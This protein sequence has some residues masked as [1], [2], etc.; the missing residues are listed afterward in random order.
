MDRFLKFAVAGLV[1]IAPIGASMAAAK[2]PKLARCDGKSRR[3]ANLYG[4][5]LPS[6]DP[7]SGTV[8]PASARPGGVDVFPQVDRDKP[9]PPA[10]S[11]TDDKTAPQVPPIS[12]IDPS[13]KSRSC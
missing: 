3:P 9:G 10:S 1:V 4:S 5:I 13:P 7:V 6:V 8:V 12:A 2:T 11:P